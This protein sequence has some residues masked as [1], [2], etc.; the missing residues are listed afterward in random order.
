MS[1]ERA[2]E[3]LRLTG[4]LEVSRKDEI[5]RALQVDGTEAAVLVDMSQVTYADSTILAELL[6]FR[7]D[8]QRVDV[9]I[10]LL[11]VSPQ[12]AR[13]IQYAGLSDAFDIFDTRS[14]ALSHLSAARTP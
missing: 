5:R 12:F 13:L 14:A 11:I 7:G 3:V 9:P 4:E 2:L 8:A 6:R 1:T 10:A